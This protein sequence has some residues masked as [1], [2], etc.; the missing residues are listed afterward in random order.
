MQPPACSASSTNLSH[1]PLL[2]SRST[3]NPGSNPSSSWAGLFTFQGGELTSEPQGN[4]VAEKLSASQWTFKP[5]D[6]AQVRMGR[7]WAVR[8]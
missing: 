3:K 6:P 8:S 5:T 4:G 7:C 2:A 1:T